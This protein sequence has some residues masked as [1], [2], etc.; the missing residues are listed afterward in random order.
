MT[1]YVKGNITAVVAALV[2]LFFADSY[3][4]AQ[5]RYS[6]EVNE[7]FRASGILR[8]PEHYYRNLIIQDIALA[9]NVTPE[10]VSLEFHYNARFSVNRCT[11]GKLEIT[12]APPLFYSPALFYHDFDISSYIRPSSG[13]MVFHLLQDKTIIADSIIFKNIIPNQDT[14]LYVS[15]DYTIPSSV[16]DFQA[17]F[18]K[19]RFFF[20]KS[21]YEQ[22]RDQILH[23]DNFL[24]AVYVGRNLLDSIGINDRS[25]E[26]PRGDLILAWI[27]MDKVNR[28]MNPVNFRDLFVP[29]SHKSNALDSIAR[30]LAI[31]Q[32]RIGSILIMNRKR[33]Q[34]IISQVTSR[35]ELANLYF[36]HLDH[37][38]DFAY[39]GDFRFVNFIEKL[40]EPVYSNAYLLHLREFLAGQAGMDDA[41][42]FSEGKRIT[43]KMIRKGEEL[44]LAG[45]QLRAMK[46]FAASARLAGSIRLY[47][48]FVYSRDKVAALKDSIAVSYVTISRK[49]ASV[50]N[51][52]LAVQY[53]EKAVNIYSN[54][55]EA[56]SQPGWLSEYRHEL[57]RGFSLQIQ[58]LIKEEKYSKCMEYLVQIQ[59]YCRNY[60][61]FI[62]PDEFH[63]QMKTV[64]QGIYKE[65]LNRSRLMLAA[66]E[67]NEAEKLLNEAIELRTAGGYNIGRE[68]EESQLELSFRQI[69]YD[70]NIEEGYRFSDL[71]EYNSALYY[72]NKAFAAGRSGIGKTDPDL[73]KN[74]LNAARR[75][76]RQVLSEGRVKAWANDY[77]GAEEIIIRI[78][79]MLNDYHVATNDSL[80]AELALLKESVSGSKCR[81]VQE[82]YRQKITQADS[83]I[84]AGNF[85]QA[86][87]LSQAAVDISFTNLDCMIRDEEAWYLKVWLEVPAAYQEQE[88]GLERRLNGPWHDYLKAFEQLR[89]DYSRNKLLD[90][91]IAFAPLTERIVA[92]TDP[93]FLKDALFFYIELKDAD[94]SFRVLKHIY[95]LGIPADPLR[96]MQHK[97]GKLMAM[98]DYSVNGSEK[99]WTTM[100]SRQ[101]SDKWFRDL[102]WSY[103]RTLLEKNR[104]KM[105]YWPVIWK[106]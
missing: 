76:I 97:L 88:A 51:P 86:R 19:A 41:A 14:G 37:Y 45:D 105:K 96:E 69:E 99:P 80:Y 68:I 33:P 58:A 4:Y 100:E 22:F 103:K 47:E 34:G 63:D 7:E 74:R 85:I 106:N 60:P 78:E 31:H 44:A 59:N 38:H 66:E 82:Q 46:Y 64:R 2:F 95:S 84:K 73:D 94:N 27:I 10:E 49:S 29:V 5:C 79:T 87:R 92:S 12:V 8:G 67:Y 23:V 9:R 43:G 72:F 62:C 42:I 25:G 102:K 70:L 75:V 81:K 55:I 104:W 65:L 28:Q 36:S 90:Y 21:S 98:R 20:D 40:A 16:N 24:A 32:K 101:V 56:K 30:L 53:L 77:E 91:G 48:S 13:Q 39:S 6:Q 89:N 52:V 17:V 61:G 54:G 18:S 15:M 1:T 50:N 93:D 57:F 71:H 35:E 26:Q 83:L 3:S 11:S